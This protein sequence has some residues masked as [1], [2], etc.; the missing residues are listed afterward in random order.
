MPTDIKMRSM[1]KER[2]RAVGY[3]KRIFSSCL[4]PNETKKTPRARE[5]NPT[6]PFVL[7]TVV[8]NAPSGLSE[9][10]MS[11][12]IYFTVAGKFIYKVPP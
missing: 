5:R 10:S 6:G 8:G 11:L 7:W 2:I 9:K 1:S 4:N 12:F 3:N